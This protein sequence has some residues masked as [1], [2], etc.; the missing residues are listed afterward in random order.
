VFFYPANRDFSY[1]MGVLSPKQNSLGKQ[2]AHPMPEP[3]Q[4]RFERKK[5][6]TA[7]TVRSGNR[8][9]DRLRWWMIDEGRR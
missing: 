8:T 3:L 9:L 7:G 2:V 4:F 5:K 6:K 1:R